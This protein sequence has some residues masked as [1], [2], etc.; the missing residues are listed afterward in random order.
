MQKGESEALHNY[1]S[2]W[3]RRLSNQMT[4]I[5]NA[6]QSDPFDLK[7]SCFD[8]HQRLVG[9]TPNKKCESR[10]RVRDLN[11]GRMGENHVS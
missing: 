1:V 4:F 5:D 10:F 11:P 6:I 8:S 2:L 7:E 9:Y 3:L